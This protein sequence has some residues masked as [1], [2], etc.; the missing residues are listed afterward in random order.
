MTYGVMNCPESFELLLNYRTHQ[1]PS[2][3]LAME[4]GT[5]QISLDGPCTTLV[6]IKPHR[7]GPAPAPEPQLSVLG[8]F[9]RKR[10][11]RKWKNNP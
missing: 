3:F 1:N 2:L 7:T 6:C 10:K 8:G 11:V 5:C 9:T 4:K